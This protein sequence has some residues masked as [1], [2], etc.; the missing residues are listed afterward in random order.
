MSV[1]A[2][3]IDNRTLAALEFIQGGYINAGVEDLKKAAGLNELAAQYYCGICYENG[4]GLD[5]NPVEAFRM[6]RRAAERGLPDAM[7]RLALFYEKGIGVD[8]NMSRSNEWMMRFKKKGGSLILPDLGRLYNEGIKHPENFA[9][10]PKKSNENISNSETLNTINNITIVQNIPNSGRTITPTQTN[11]EDS[12]IFKLENSAHISDV[13]QDIPINPQSNAQTFALII[14]NENYQDVAKV[15]NA[16]NDGIVFSDYCKK[17]LGMPDSNVHLVKDA[18]LN[19]IKRKFNLVKQIAEAYNGEINIIIYYAGHGIPDESSK[20]A[21]LLPIDG[22]PGDLSTCFGVDDLYAILGKIPAEK[23]IVF[24]DACFSGA[25]RGD[26]MLASTRGVVLKAKTSVPAGNMIV[27]S[28]SQGDETAYPYEDERHGLFTYFL[29]KKLKDSKGNVNLGEL[30]NYLR[31]NVIRKSLVV[32]GKQ[33]TPTAVSS[34]V[35]NSEWKNWNLR[36]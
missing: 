23:V 11:V 32:N 16:L 10:N 8:I 19:N 6:Y 1:R 3:S 7:Y 5:K 29:L 25:L 35:V 9:L 24:L 26:G 12:S 22:F 27:V 21:F 13:D 30:V 14:A 34:V 20:K 36:Q 33:Q 2:Q 28:A 15:P 18:T 4:Y 31:E 17:T